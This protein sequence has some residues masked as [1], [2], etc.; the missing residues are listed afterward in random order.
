[1]NLSK[2]IA[3]WIRQQ[4]KESKAKGIVVGLSGGIDSACVVLLAKMAV[5]KNVLGL[6]MPCQSNPVDEKYAMLLAKKFNIKVKKIP[7]DR[8]CE[9]F[10]KTV[11]TK[12]KLALANLKPRLRMITLYL[13]ANSLNYLVAGTGNKSEAM[14][15]YFTKHGD[16]G[17]DI[18]PLGDLLKVDVRKLARELDVPCQIIERVPTAGLW[19]GQTDEG[20]LGMSYEDLDRAIVAIQAGKDKSFKPKNIIL[21]VKR[22]MNKSEH[23]RY[24]PPIFK[25]NTK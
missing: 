7:L 22:L 19:E 3:S 12:N 14:V 1:M 24:L 25:K 11:P 5:G 20:E 16:G 8:V 15:G 4:V 13:F 2:K 17:V 9:S 18:L 6:I 23:K 10:L 21:K